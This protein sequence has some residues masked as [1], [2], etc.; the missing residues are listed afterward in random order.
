[1]W[2]HPLLFPVKMCSS[3][4]MSLWTAIFARAARAVRTLALPCC[5]ALLAAI[6]A[7]APAAIPTAAPALK[8]G[9]TAGICVAQTVKKGKLVPLRQSVYRYRYTRVK[10]GRN[11]GKFRRTIIRATVQVKTSCITQC[12]QLRKKGGALQPVFRT[13]RVSVLEPRRGRLVKVKR[14]RRVWLLGPCAS[15]PSIE[16]LGTPVTIR[17]LDQS[18]LTFDFSAF[19]RDA[20]LTGALKGYIPG[21]LLPDVDNQII[22]T[23]GSFQL[24]KTT[25]FND[26]VCG[27]VISDSI[28]TADPSV[29][30][31]DAGKQSTLTLGANG[32]LT[33][34]TYTV[35]S[36]PLELRNGDDGCGRPYITT[37]YSSASETMRLSGTVGAQGL[38]QVPIR[39]P[40][41]DID[42]L[43]CLSPGVTTQACNGFQIPLPATVSLSLVVAVVAEGT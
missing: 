9:G 12:V 7:A 29:L 18:T 30:K 36:L 10:R 17:L 14:L 23:S 35:L 22:L 26:K 42:L 5:V 1:M 21:K 34:V 4:R 2:R 38:A 16:T 25:M 39:M 13:R 32:K 43:G 8:K 27:G 6:P 24:G 20:P 33:A 15:L 41:A 3:M 28:R 19:K 31:L 11:K 40:A 37:G